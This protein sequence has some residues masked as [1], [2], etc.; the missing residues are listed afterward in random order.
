MKNYIKGMLQKIIYDNGNGYIIGKLKIK[1]TNDEELEDYV[2]KSM[3]FTGYFDL[4]NENTTYIL[5]GNIVNHPRYGLQYQVLSY[6]KI[7]PDDKDGVKEF[8]CSDLF[9]G[10][11]EKLASSIVDILGD[12]ALNKIIEDKNCLT[13]VPKLSIK[14]ANQIYDTLIKYEESHKTIVYLTELGFTMHDALIV[15][16]IYKSNTLCEIEHNIYDILDKTDEISFP[17]IDSIALKQTSYE[18][19][20]RVKA[21]I[22]YIMKSLIYQNGDTYLLLD[23][24]KNNVQNYLQDFI[25]DELFDDYL[26]ELS[27]EGKIIIEENKYYILD[28]YKAEMFIVSKFKRVLSKEL[29]GYKKLDN[30]ILKLEKENEFVYSDMQ[31]EAIKMALKN[32]ITVITGG[33]GTGKTTIVK[34]IIGAYKF[35]NKIKDEDDMIA[36]LA[37]TGR[38]AKRLSE[39]TNV[40]SSTIH[41]FLKWNKENNEFGINEFNKVFHKLI[42]IDEASMIDINL[43]ASLLKGLTDNIQ[44]VLVGDYNQLPSVGP[45]QVLKDIIESNVINVVKLDLLYRQSMESYIPILS[46]NIK[47]NC[48]DNF[49]ES[50]DDYQFL[51]CNSESIKMNL[52]HITKQIIDKGY[53]YKN[54]QIMAPTYLGLN[55]IDIL[56]K[57]LQDVFNP[58][59][60]FKKEYK[61]GNIIYRENDKILQLVNMPDDNVFNGDIGIIEQIVP[62]TISESKRE[63]IYINFDGNI[64][65]YLPK[66]LNKI[67]HG[68]A[69]SIHKSQGSEFDVVI[70][71]LC[72]S[73]NRMLYRK[74]IYTGVTRAK[75][76]LILIGDPNAFIKGVENN[77]EYKRKTY[78][79]EKLSNMYNKTNNV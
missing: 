58:K 27:I 20:Y 2:N 10:I 41:R 49:L 69:I 62:A 14:K 5:Y 29:N 38:A 4:L 26:N 42:I 39:S 25:S 79:K 34:A 45:G 19:I 56:N 13:L 17:K 1:E 23:E 28:I 7:K 73:Y 3:T 44:I 64:I 66:D 75:K 15:Y 40:S 74:L 24:I 50:Y 46:N 77:N 48:V 31:K 67:K 6:E 37:P 55:G 32:R 61:S 47:N 12:D 22:I 70:M 60:T 78:L 18:E 43:F 63:E 33:P 9:S 52:C 36:L 8:L 21:C 71:P 30:V 76:K 68:Y 53:N 16:N 11:G 59:E 65:K 54:F 51:K 35:I 57:S 72:M